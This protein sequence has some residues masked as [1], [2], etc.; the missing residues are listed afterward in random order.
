MLAGI[1][2]SMVFPLIW[3]DALPLYYFPW[4]FLI[5]LIGCLIATLVTPPTDER[6]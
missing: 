3:P 1:V 6:C 4:M 5:S 2:A